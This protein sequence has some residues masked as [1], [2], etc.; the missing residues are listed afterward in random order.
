MIPAPESDR[1]LGMDYY[2]T[3]SPGCGGALRASPEDFLVEEVWD[4]RGY[5]GGRYLVLEV[6]KTDWDTHHLIRELSRQ[7]RISQKRFGWA[8][9]KDKRAVTSQRISVM[10]LDESALKRITL[11]DIEIRV[12]GRTNRS[13]GLGDLQGNRFAIKISQMACPDA[14]EII[15]KI[16][17][18][19]SVHK[20]VPN[21]FGIQRFGEARPVTHKVGEAL[22]RGDIEG[23]VFIYL[24]MPFPGELEATRE[25]RQRLWD[26]RDIPAALKEFPDY[27]RY[28]KAMLNRLVERP[29]DYAGSFDV[30]SPNLKR[31]FVH[32]YQSYIFNEILSRRL[33]AGLPLD[34][35]VE[36]DTVCFTRDDLPDMDKLQVVD[37]SNI[38]AVNRL[39]DRSRAYV[40]IPL[41]GFESQ[42]ASGAQ[43][44][45]EQAVIEEEDLDLED[46]RIPANPD[47]G[48][49]GARR[50]AL[51]RVSPEHSV[52]GDQAV[53]K[54]FLPAGSYATVV[55]REYMKS[56]NLITE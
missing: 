25:A 10:N 38:S 28:E 40:T 33:E 54:F 55:L 51:L 44:E 49:R 17:T 29:G 4:E 42:M 34:R 21:Y 32:A 11:P 27:L 23:A 30:L 20:G 1:L 45:I 22:V 8:G 56:G 46:F 43:G 12:L 13:V 16:T 26:S 31:L 7:L 24:A 41:F 9:T 15:S 6:K 53:L 19:I 47:L 2:L 35:A 37:G 36:G 48:S 14:S 3:D 18:E 39:A 5:E 50:A 52:Q